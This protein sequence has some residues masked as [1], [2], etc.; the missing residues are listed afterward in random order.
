MKAKFLM[1]KPIGTVS[2]WES[3]DFCLSFGSL[4][5]GRNGL[6]SIL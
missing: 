5:S 6:A 4:L 1:K 2:V 3:E